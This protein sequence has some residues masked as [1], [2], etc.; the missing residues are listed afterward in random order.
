MSTVD[1]GPTYDYLFLVGNYTSIMGRVRSVA[2]GKVPTVASLNSDCL[3][4]H[5]DMRIPQPDEGLSVQVY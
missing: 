1:S 3:V 2:V 4:V 5:G